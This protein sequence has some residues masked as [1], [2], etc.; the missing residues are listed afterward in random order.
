VKLIFIVNEQ[1][2]G[3]K[4]AHKWRKIE[5]QLTIQYDAIMTNYRGHAVD[6]ARD[7]AK[8]DEI[9]LLLVA[10]GGDGTIHEVIEGAAGYKHIMIG[11]MK[12][13]SGNDFAR[14]YQVFQHIEELEHYVKIAK[15]IDYRRSEAIMIDKLSLNETSGTL[16]IT[17][18]DERIEV[19][20]KEEVYTKVTIDDPDMHF[21]VNAREEQSELAK[22]EVATDGLDTE[23]HLQSTGIE[24]HPFKVKRMDI[25]EIG[26]SHI[27]EQC[28]VNN[29]GIGF[30]AYV[31]RKSNESKLKVML[32]SIG[33]GGL[34]YTLMTIRALFTFKRFGVKITN[35]NVEYQFNNVWFITI[36]NQPYFGGGMKISPRSV[37]S[38]KKLELVVV[39]NISRLK[40][41]LV[42]ATVFLGKHERFKEV[43]FLQGEGFTIKTDIPMVSHVDGELF[44][45]IKAQESVTC[46]VSKRSWYLATPEK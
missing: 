11:A 16:L 1:A 37:P 10:I 30:D 46:Q 42:F 9:P 39:H 17:E 26:S 44:G 34:V 3:G 13:G 19:E 31:T 38:D 41:L 40:L 8:E 20:S 28:F 24:F 12:A 21:V 5:S 32:N 43:S 18:K 27:Q 33:L 35:N 23:S 14:G 25:G 2:G 6:I 15:K 36:C 4:G 29:A 22:A 45:I 7:L